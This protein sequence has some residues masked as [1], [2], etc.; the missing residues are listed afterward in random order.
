V[1]RKHFNQYTPTSSAYILGKDVQRE[2][3]VIQ[4]L[5]V[6]TIVYDD[7]FDHSVAILENKSNLI[8]TT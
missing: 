1:F 4:Y 8:H 3:K 2:L 5:I 7:N 6:H